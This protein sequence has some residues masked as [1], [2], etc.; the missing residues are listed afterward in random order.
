VRVRVHLPCLLGAEQVVHEPHGLEMPSAAQAW[1]VRE[2]A[3]LACGQA[4]PPTLGPLPGASTRRVRGC[5]TSRSGGTRTVGSA[6]ASAWRPASMA[7]LTTVRLRGAEPL[8]HESV[9][10]DQAPQA[11][12]LQWG[13]EPMPHEGEP[14]DQAQQALVLQWGTEPVPQ[15]AE[16]VDQAPQAL[17]LQWGSE[18]V[19]HEAV[20]ADRAQQ[21]LVMPWGSEP[22]P[23]QAEQADQAPQALVLQWGVPPRDQS[24][25]LGSAQAAHLACA[26]Q[27]SMGGSA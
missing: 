9:Q 25:R 4:L 24:W 13:I 15:E 18:P 17:V 19:P 12:V 26:C 20:Q 5:G 6:A 22:V 21:A 2:Q 23:H 7:A 3:S 1:L 8:P 10:A 14:A 27:E 11:L 16:Q